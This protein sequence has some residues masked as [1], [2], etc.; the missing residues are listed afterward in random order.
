MMFF[1]IFIITLLGFVKCEDKIWR[2]TPPPIPI[3]SPI[4]LVKNED[5]IWRRTPPPIPISSSP[6]PLVNN[7]DKIWR[8]TPP[9]IPISSS[10]IP[11]VNNEDKIR[12]TLTPIC[13]TPAPIK[14]KD[15]IWIRTLTPICRTPATIT[16]EDNAW[17]RMDAKETLFRRTPTPKPYIEFSVHKDFALPKYSNFQ[18]KSWY[19]NWFYEDEKNKVYTSMIYGPPPIPRP[20]NQSDYSIWEFLEGP[21]FSSVIDFFKNL[22]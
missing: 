21:P 2:R 17:R 22:F 18:R 7:E 4:P 5:K 12:R 19:G 3:N 14:C 8:R 20:T 6:I 15:K 11:L 16:S 10:P 9:P 1:K 13:R